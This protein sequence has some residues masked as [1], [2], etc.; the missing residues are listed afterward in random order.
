MP[1]F[2][3]SKLLLSTCQRDLFNFDTVHSSAILPCGLG[4]RAQLGLQKATVVLP[5]GPKRVT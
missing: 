2:L 1:G 4:K 3:I 5:Q